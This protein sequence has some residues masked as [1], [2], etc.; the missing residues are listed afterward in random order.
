MDIQTPVVLM[1]SWW[2]CNWPKSKKNAEMCKS[3]YS[4]KVA[5]ILIHRFHLHEPI[6]RSTWK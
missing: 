6:S 4:V 1:I 5:R 3:E 2:K